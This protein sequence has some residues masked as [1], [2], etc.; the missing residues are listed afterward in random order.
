MFLATQA[1]FKQIITSLPHEEA[2]QME[3]ACRFPVA[4]KRIGLLGGSFNPAHIGHLHISQE[5]L[6]RLRLDEVWWLVSPQNPLKSSHDMRPLSERIQGCKVLT[7]G[8]KFL[9]VTA[10]EIRLETRYSID[11]IG[12]LLKRYPQTRFVWLMG[13][14]N[15]LQMPKWRQW[16]DIV[17]TISM[18][19]FARSP[20]DFRAM[21]GIVASRFRRWYLPHN[22]AQTLLMTSPP[23]WQFILM[24]RQAI[25]ASAI[26]HQQH[27]KSKKV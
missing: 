11:T 19:V 22:N 23:A 18:A 6:R 4:K 1:A 21:H 12:F 2:R 9:R 5:A 13:A 26:R 20:Y 27:L 3:R 14:D 25:S 24:R 8:N 17:R 10:L 7:K 16:P 15:L